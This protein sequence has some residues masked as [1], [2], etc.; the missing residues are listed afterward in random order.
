MDWAE[1][2]EYRDLIKDEIRFEPAKG[3]K[4]ILTLEER[5][6]YAPDVVFHVYSEKGAYML[7]VHEIV[8]VMALDVKT[9]THALGETLSGNFRIHMTTLRADLPEEMEIS[10]AE[11]DGSHFKLSFE[12]QRKVVDYA[13]NL[14]NGDFKRIRPVLKL[15]WAVDSWRHGAKAMGWTHPATKKPEAGQLNKGKDKDEK[16][17]GGKG[18]ID[19]FGSVWNP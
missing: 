9:R 13:W 2:Q 19:P 3:Q 7:R 18:R 6:P 15:I 5:H 17:G 16:K 8:D 12:K 1:L 4:W 11:R 14:P 10:E